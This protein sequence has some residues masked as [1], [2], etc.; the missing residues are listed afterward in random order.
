MTQGF[1]DIFHFVSIRFGKK[2]DAGG[3]HENPGRHDIKRG[4]K[5]PGG[6]KDAFCHGRPANAALLMRVEYFMMVFCFREFVK[7]KAAE[8]KRKP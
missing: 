3:P 7:G 5:K 6:P 2:G 4:V 8:Q 1:T